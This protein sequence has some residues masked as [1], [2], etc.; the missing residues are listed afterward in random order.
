MAPQG[1]EQKDGTGRKKWRS[2]AGSPTQFSE[3]ASWF[4]FERTYWSER[5]RANLLLVHY[6]DLKADL[7][8]EMRRVAEF[9]EISVAENLWPTLVRAASFEEMKRHGN[10]LQTTI[11]RA[12]IGGAETFFNRGENDRW[13]GVL[14]AADVAAYEARL[15]E[16]LEAECT[17]WLHLGRHRFSVSTS[18]ERSAEQ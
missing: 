1:A 18:P 16:R 10:Q 5:H 4:G 9:L 2:P 6:R 13:R 17:E 12:L 8:G 11:A 7:L 15:R 14:T 3:E